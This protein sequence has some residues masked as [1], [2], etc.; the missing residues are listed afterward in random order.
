MN[1][2]NLITSLFVIFTGLYVIY[3]GDWCKFKLKYAAV[4]I[5]TMAGIWITTFI[6]TQNNEIACSMSPSLCLAYGVYGIARNFAIVLFHISVGRDAII[7]KKKDRRSHHR[8]E[9]RSGRVDG[10]MA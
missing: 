8:K 4:A 1:S 7:F 5:S 6:I 2:L 10:K 3:A 9:G